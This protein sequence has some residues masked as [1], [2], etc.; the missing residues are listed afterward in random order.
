MLL[1]SS[2]TRM[3]GTEGPPGNWERGAT[4]RSAA[5]TQVPPSYWST[6]NRVRQRRRL[7]CVSEVD[8]AEGPVSNC[9]RGCDLAAALVQTRGYQGMIF[10]IPF[11]FLLVDSLPLS[12]AAGCVAS[13]A[14]VVTAAGVF[15][16]EAAAVGGAAA[17]GSESVVAGCPSVA[18]ASTVDPPAAPLPGVATSMTA[19]LPTG[20]EPP[21]P[22]IRAC[23]P[24]PVKTSP[25]EVESVSGCICGGPLRAATIISFPG[26]VFTMDSGLL[27]IP[28]FGRAA[29]CSA[30]IHANAFGS[31]CGTGTPNATSLFFASPA[32]GESG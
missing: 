30:C 21:A 17:F 29:F 4:R 22:A 25:R 13:S 27:I 24:P 7:Y 6:A 15:G 32:N 10:L 19:V 8:T 14:G 23:P 9:M 26:P 20:L 28:G 3:F 12:V 1:L 16:S 5:R 11:F 31:G 18:G 2:A